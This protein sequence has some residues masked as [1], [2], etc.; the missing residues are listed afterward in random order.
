VASR[1][2]TRRATGR[3]AGKVDYVALARIRFEIRKFLAFSEAAAR[4]EALT[5]QQHQALLS[6]KGFSEEKSVSVGEVAD[7]L[8]IRHHTAVELIDRMAKL[9]LVLRS[10]D[11]EDGR[12][13]L[14]RLTSEGERRLRKLS[15]VHAQELS[16]IGETLTDLLRPFRT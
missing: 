13:S 3:S 14:I 10:P 7:F 9:G 16:E 12:R 5:P 8:L 1:T 15:E 4:K 2:K 11:P 6:I